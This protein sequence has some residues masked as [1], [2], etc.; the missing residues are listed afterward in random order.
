MYPRGDERF[1]KEVSLFRILGNVAGLKIFYRAAEG[2]KSSGE[3]IKELGLTPRKYYRYFKRLRDLGIIAPNEGGGSQYSLTDMGRLLH[4]LVFNELSSVLSAS[5]KDLE[6]LKNIGEESRLTLITDY[7]GLVETM[8]SLI[9]RSRFQIFLATR[10][11]DLSVTQSLIHAV[12][13]GVELRTVTSKDVKLLEFMKL[14]MG[15]VRRLRSDVL[16]LYGKVDNYRIGNV[17]LS[18][19]VVDREVV[20]FE[21]PSEEF[22][23]AFLSRN[24]VVVEGFY[25]SFLELWNASSKFPSPLLGG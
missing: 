3:I 24:K 14:V 12:E 18:F 15:F 10:Y 25:E 7:A 4:N 23:L 6:F 2:I 22:K 11:L 16:K 13:R 1:E 5:P 21:L 20:I 17:S 19:V 9:E 8:I